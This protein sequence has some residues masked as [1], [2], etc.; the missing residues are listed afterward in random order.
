M[1]VVSQRTTPVRIVR[2]AALG[3]LLGTGLIAASAIAGKTTA[4]GLLTASGLLLTGLSLS[5]IFPMLMHDTPRCV[6]SGHALNLIGFQSGSG[7][8][9]YT[10]LPILIGT[11]LR[12]YST[13]WLGS[14]LSGLAVIL[15]ALVVL[16]ERWALGIAR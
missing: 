11:L 15:I 6:G 14:L 1:G 8:L 10:L 9:G 7:Q 2:G 3:V 4:A 12:L 16:R 5:P 13:E